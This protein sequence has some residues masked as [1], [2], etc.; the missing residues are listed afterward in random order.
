MGEEKP[1]EDGQRAWP[2]LPVPFGEGKSLRCYYVATGPIN[3][4]TAGWYF[5]PAPCFCIGGNNSE[6][7]IWYSWWS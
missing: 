2:L 3:I 6:G 4:Q 1:E 7:N 5:L